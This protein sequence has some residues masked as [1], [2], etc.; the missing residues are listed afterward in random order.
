MKLF[1]GEIERC[2]MVVVGRIHECPCIE[3]NFDDFLV[4]LLGRVMQCCPTISILGIW[5]CVCCQQCFDIS[6]VTSLSGQMQ[7]SQLVF[8]EVVVVLV[9]FVIL[10][11][12]VIGV[13]VKTFL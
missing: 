10:V 3:Q 7:L 6:L 9:S 11:I 8:C 1:D 12:L 13:R 2:L 5:I 4:S